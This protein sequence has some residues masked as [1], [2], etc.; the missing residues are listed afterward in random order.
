MVRRN[1]GS[2]AV[3]GFDL[4]QG[5]QLTLAVAPLTLL[6]VLLGTLDCG[7]ERAGHGDTLRLESDST[8]TAKVTVTSAKARV[9]VVSLKARGAGA[10]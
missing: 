2:A 3:I 1:W 7:G 8:E 6:H 10:A 9:V 4:V 5:Q